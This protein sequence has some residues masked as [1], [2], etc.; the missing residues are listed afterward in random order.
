MEGAALNTPPATPPERL[1]RAVR[2][3][4]PPAAREVVVGDLWETYQNPSQ[5]AREAL[6][7]VP[8][9]VFSQMRRHFNLP[10]LMLQA[11]VLY[12]CLGAWAA[13]LLLPVLTV[14]QAYQPLARPTPRRAMREATLLAFALVIFLQG[15]WSSSHGRSPMT[16]NGV[17]LGIGLFF[18]G[19]CLVPF[20]C[21]L[22][23]SLIVGSDR[24]PTLARSD[25]TAKELAQNHAHY[26]AR[27][28]AAQLLEAVLLGVMAFLPWYLMGA[29]PL[30]QMLA[31][32]YGA[33][34]LF[35]MLNTPAANQ[36]GDFL[37]LRASYQR[38]L[39]RHQQLR[40]FLWWLWCAPALLMLH[41]NAVAAAGSG[42][43]AGGTLRG[44]AAIMLC[45]FVT[46]LNRE[47]AGWTQE[48]IGALGR[49][50]ERLA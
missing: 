45:F 50:H 17:W 8:F 42:Q 36:T 27:S 28:R 18:I 40:H 10:A 12:A 34:A 49:M 2:V 13:A 35:L 23:A 19:P 5:Y 15:V 38:D 11:M 32:F 7:I 33:A 46:A 30:G 29:S 44:I 48:Q 20:L 21:L 16:V 37:S 22:R 39:M 41:D 47:G 25:W 6:C 24:R 31:L 14:A 4:I 9:I 43:L 26:A 1:D 3:L